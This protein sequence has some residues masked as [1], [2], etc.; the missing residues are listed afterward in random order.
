MD[1][2]IECPPHWDLFDHLTGPAKRAPD[3]RTIRA[4]IE[5][6]RVLVLAE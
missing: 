6:G 2:E 5:G 3:L 4:R 1:F